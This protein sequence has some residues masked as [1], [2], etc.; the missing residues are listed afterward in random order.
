MGKLRTGPA[1][2]STFLR[3][4]EALN[5]VAADVAE[6]RDLATSCK[7]PRVKAI[8]DAYLVQLEAVIAA[9][10]STTAAAISTK[11]APLPTD[12]DDNVPAATSATSR[13]VNAT[14]ESAVSVTVI[15]QSLPAAPTVAPPMPIRIS[16]SATASSTEIIHYT[17]ISS[18]G[19]DQD[20]YG[21]DPNNVYVYLLNFEGIGEHKDSVHC[22]FTPSSFDLK[23]LG[24]KSKNWRLFVG[25]LDKEIDPAH[26][27]A[28]VKKNKITITMR[29]VKGQYG[30]DSWIDL[31]SKRS[32]AVSKEKDPGAGLMDM[33]K[34]MYDDGDDQMKKTLGE[35][36]LKSRQDQMRG[37]TGVSAPSFGDD[38]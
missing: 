29:K 22:T 14:P 21:K 36:M 5:D 2:F 34:Q 20:S 12:L 17:T 28:V 30:Y 16:S 11:P 38:F 24:F 19:W 27:K 37:G 10:V 3:G 25:N 9:G 13:V 15:E 35:A 6:L 4:M 18:Y 32:G 7:R 26:S 8:L 1:T 33:M 31:T 23:V